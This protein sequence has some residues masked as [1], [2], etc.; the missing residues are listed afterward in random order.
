MKTVLG[1]G[2]PKTSIFHFNALKFEMQTESHQQ[3]PEILI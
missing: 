2:L 1:Q 3:S